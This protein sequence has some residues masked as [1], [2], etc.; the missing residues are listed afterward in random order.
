MNPF[1]SEPKMIT[2]FEKQPPQPVHI[3]GEQAFLCLSCHSVHTSS[4]C[5]ACDKGPS[6]PLL[7]WL[8]KPKGKRVVV[9]EEVQ[10]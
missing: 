8:E 1:T 4:R 2:L 5:S 3:P 10:H 9:M 7:R 6:V